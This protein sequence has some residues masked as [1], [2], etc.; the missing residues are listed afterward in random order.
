MLT[1]NELFERARMGQCLYLY[2]DEIPDLEALAGPAAPDP[3]ATFA[4]TASMAAIAGPADVT[5][6]A[7]HR[8]LVRVLP[9]PAP[10]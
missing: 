10:R 6:A 9:R 4:V 3:M 1:R 8:L 5:P 7:E 2:R